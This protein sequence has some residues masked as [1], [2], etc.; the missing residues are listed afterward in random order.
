[1]STGTGLLGYNMYAYCNN[2]PIFFVDST[3][4]GPVLL[5]LVI[6]GVLLLTSCDDQKYSPPYLNPY[7]KMLAIYVLPLQKTLLLFG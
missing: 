2:N 6:I 7:E 5:V 4:S 1:M 3:G